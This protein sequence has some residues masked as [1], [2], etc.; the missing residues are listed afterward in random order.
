MNPIIAI[1]QPIDV[2]AVFKKDTSKRLICLPAKIRYKNQE[3]LITTMALHHPTK[4]GKR[5]I[6]IF[7]VSDGTND[8]RLE[9]NAES[10]SWRLQAMITV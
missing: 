3:I 6:H 1:N 2:I 4:I 5:M 9:F 7:D 10:L 8:Y